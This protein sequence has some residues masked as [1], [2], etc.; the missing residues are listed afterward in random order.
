MGVFS[1]FFDK[2]ILKYTFL[3]FL[4]SLIFWGVVFFFFKD[5]IYDVLNVYLA[6]I[7]YFGDKVSE[8]LSAIGSGIVIF[9]LYYISVISTLGIF[10]S[11]FI[12]KIVE[13]INEKHYNL[14]KRNVTFKDTVKGV[15]I[16]LKSFFIYFV[17][18]IFTFFLLFIPIVNIFYQMFMWSVLNKKPLVFD[19]SYLF[20][21]PEEIEEKYNIKIWTLV[22]FSS[23]IYFIPF[24]S[25]FGYTFQLILMTHFVLNNLLK[26]SR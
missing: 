12:D 6:K 8:V 10:S 5:F 18:F 17:I 9:L 1:D 14:P 21:Q 20:T 23:L 26:G 22:F 19:S 25:L 2:K 11:F 24:V 13:R 3:P 4:L 7:P 15:L 16:A